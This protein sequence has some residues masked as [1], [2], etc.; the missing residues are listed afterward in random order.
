MPLTARWQVDTIFMLPGFGATAALHSG[1]PC[2]ERGRGSRGAVWTRPFPTRSLCFRS[3]TMGVK[4]R[5][6]RSEKIAGEGLK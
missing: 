1:A 2:G 3:C 6:G 5:P 4:I